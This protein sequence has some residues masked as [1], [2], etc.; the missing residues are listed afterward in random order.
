MSNVRIYKNKQILPIIFS[1]TIFVAIVITVSTL[2]LFQIKN[3][4]RIRVR[5][6]LQ[7]VAR[8]TQEAI[9]IW[10]D[11]EKSIIKK[12]AMS[13]TVIKE[14]LNLLKVEKNKKNLC[15]SNAMAKLRSFFDLY[16][17]ELNALGF[18]IIDKN[19][20]SI[21]SMRNSNVGT[22]NIIAK[23]RKHLLEKAFRG[24]TVF[25]PS[26]V[27]D[28]PLPDSSGRIGSDRPTLFVATPIYYKK[29]I[30]AVLTIRL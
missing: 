21:G 10:V 23:E 18:F 2:A 26:M 19:Y 12:L 8:T 7:A 30:I 11:Q 25:I 4:T 24:E 29:K 20:I 28:V 3:E 15:N 13:Q 1:F 17:K 9:Y 6:T 16:L 27:S 14:T 22:L 5:N